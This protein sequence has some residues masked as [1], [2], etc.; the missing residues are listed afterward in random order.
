MEK[1]QIYSSGSSFYSN[2]KSAFDL[3]SKSFFGELKDGKIIYS[4]YE[5]LYLVEKGRAELEDKKALVK[6]MKKKEIQYL[7]FKD[8]RNKGYILK[9]GLKFGSDFRVYDK[10][11]NPK[12]QHAHYLLY[13]ISSKDKLNIKDVSAKT[14]VAHSTNKI[15]LLAIVDSEQDI[16]Y[17]EVCW[18]SIQ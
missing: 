7:A 13:A 8:L 5:A 16:T 18:K 15:L 1:I 12:Q 9:E 6:I 17:M 2:K 4:P 3:V 11:K 14:R 10:G